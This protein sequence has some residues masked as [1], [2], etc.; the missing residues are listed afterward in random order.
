M[1]YLALLLLLPS[2]IFGLEIN[3]VTTQNLDESRVTLQGNSFNG[4]SQLLQTGSDGFIEDADID[5]STATKLG[6][7]LRWGAS[8]EEIIVS[9]GISVSG[10][11]TSSGNVILGNAASDLL[12]VAPSSITL[13]NQTTIWA[14]VDGS[15]FRY[16]ESSS[17]GK[18]TIWDSTAYVQYVDSTPTIASP[19]FV[20]VTASN[21]PSNARMA[22]LKAVCYNTQDGSA[23]VSEVLLCVKATGNAVTTCTTLVSRCLGRADLASQV[24]ADTAFFWQ[25]LNGSQSFD[26]TCRTAGTLNTP[27]C[28]IAG[29]GYCQ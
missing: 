27:N 13:L 16:S 25:P 15:V 12:T 11:L 14:N 3:G 21:L 8:N 6:T 2:S 28:I 20:S 17:C 4:A 24:S 23:Q 1:K 19:G 10:N 22:Y 18:S 9:T 29:A 7:S 26:F 5:N